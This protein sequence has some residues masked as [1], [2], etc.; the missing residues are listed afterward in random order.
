MSENSPKFG[1]RDEYVDLRSSVN[2][3]QGKFK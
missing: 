1:E 2:T 3:K